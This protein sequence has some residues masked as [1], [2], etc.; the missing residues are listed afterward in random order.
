MAGKNGD[1]AMA[2][3]NTALDAVNC[4]IVIQEFARA[5]LDGKLRRGIYLGDI[6]VEHEDV[7]DNGVHVSKRRVQNLWIKK[8]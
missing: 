2:R 5:K 3:F 6:T 7:F 8:K 1:G 4:S